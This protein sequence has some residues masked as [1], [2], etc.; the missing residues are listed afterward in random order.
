M[1]KYYI[2]LELT[3]NQADVLLT[4]LAAA[5]TND[6]THVYSPVGV[7]ELEVVANQILSDYPDSLLATG[8]Q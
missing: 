2:N 8:P 6:K 7:A 4:V 3:K 5:I 1:T